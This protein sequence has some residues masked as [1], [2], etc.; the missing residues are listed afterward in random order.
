MTTCDGHVVI[1]PRFGTEEQPQSIHIEKNVLAVNLEKINRL[2]NS[3]PSQL[4]RILFNF[5][6]KD[7]FSMR[8]SIYIVKVKI[9]KSITIY[10]LICE[11]LKNN[12]CLR[13]NLIKI[14]LLITVTNILT[15]RKIARGIAIIAVL[16]KNST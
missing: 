8:Y 3:L 9:L 4:E 15:S 1:P 11:F 5:F 6:G 13:S 2:I 7:I 10:Y 12:N 16:V 14:I